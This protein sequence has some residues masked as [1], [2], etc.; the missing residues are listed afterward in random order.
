MRI[1][2]HIA[3]LKETLN[4]IAEGA[5]WG[6]YRCT[7]QGGEQIRG[8]HITVMIPAKATLAP[9]A[10]EQIVDLFNEHHSNVEWDGNIKHTNHSGGI[11]KGKYYELIMDRTDD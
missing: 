1:K 5:T 6:E 2:E 9:N 7:E 11:Y 4:K 8:P 3:V 10:F